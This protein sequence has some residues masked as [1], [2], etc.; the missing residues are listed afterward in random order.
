M[1]H[2]T[3]F[4][5]IVCVGL[6]AY[7]TRILGY[8]LLKNRHLSKK[9]HTNFTG[10]PRLCFDISDCTLLCYGSTSQLDCN[11]HH[12]FFAACYFSLLPTVLISIIA[13]GILRYFML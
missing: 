11:Y 6:T 3:T 4:I 7:L 5:A 12:A 8:L 2:M 10:D 1:I 9:N 13:T